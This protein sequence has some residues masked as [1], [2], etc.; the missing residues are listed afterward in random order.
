MSI[1]SWR[2]MLNVPFEKIEKTEYNRFVIHHELGGGEFTMYFE[3]L[4]KLVSSDLNIEL[5]N[6]IK[7]RHSLSFQLQK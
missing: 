6:I 2:S 1:E 3:S 5:K 4:M 7:T